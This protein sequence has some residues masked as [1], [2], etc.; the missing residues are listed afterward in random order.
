M[1]LSRVQF[2]VLGFGAALLVAA[3]NIDTR[4]HAQASASNARRTTAGNPITGEGLPNPAPIVTRNW[5]QLPAGRKW[6]TTAGIAI[7]PIDGNVWAYER[8]GAG[9]AGGGPVDCDNT[10]V[11]PIFKFDRRTGAVLA[12]FGKGV[13]VTPHGIAVDRQGNVWITDFAAN[14]AGTKGHQVHKFNP[15]GEKLLSLGVAGKA[16][17]AD[18]LF[19]QPNAVAIGPDGSIYVADGHDAQGM[20]TP[21]AVAEGIR[22]GATSRISKFSPDGRFIKSWGG[23][24]VRHGEFRTPHALAFDAR[25]RLWV[26]DRGNHR[27]EIFDQNGTYLESRYLYGRVSGLFIKGDTVYAI[28]SE[29][30]PYNDPNR[31]DGVRIG[32]L[33]EDRITGFIPPFDRDDR[34]Y[35]GTAGEGVAVDADGNVYAAE[36][37]N[38]IIQAGGA[39]TKYSV[40]P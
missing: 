2:S 33:D 23:I 24:G 29:S 32:A 18:G 12:N 34:V 15:K 6:G 25:S 26:A 1:A 5:G 19:N 39:F 13:M 37:P 30:G 16:G 21:N 17:N 20:T 10:P 4:A 3:Q 9:T 11:D 28:D 27:I 14:Q 35:Q 38:S 31:H 36:G 7:D 8:C 22:R 40:R